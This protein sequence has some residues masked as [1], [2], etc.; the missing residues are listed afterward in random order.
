MNQYQKYI[1]EDL[2]IDTKLAAYEI[3]KTNKGSYQ[4]Y[5]RTAGAVAFS[6]NNGIIS[7][8]RNPN[9]HVH[10]YEITVTHPSIDNIWVTK[11]GKTITGDII[12]E[13]TRTISIDFNK[14]SPS[15]FVS[16]KENLT[17]PIELPIEYTDAD[18]NKWDEKIKA[19]KEEELAKKAN[20]IVTNGI[21]FVNILFRPIDITYHHA[22]ATLYFEE[23][24]VNNN[25][26]L[27]QIMG[28]FKSEEG[29]FFIPICNIGYGTYVAILKQYDKDDNLIY[30][31]KQ[32]SF[33]L[34]DSYQSPM[35]FVH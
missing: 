33:L 29:M 17:D 25:P 19:E 9:Y 18:K 35:Y 32:T 15:L 26:V 3:K 23:R 16:F 11:D 12:D 20:I 8:T 24:D 5:D 21:S 10:E 30:E 28:D 4:E 14:K 2:K 7:I 27:L 22:I 34:K 6:F 13:T 1:A 31:S